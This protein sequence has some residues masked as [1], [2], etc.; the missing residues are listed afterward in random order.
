VAD[1]INARTS[2]IVSQSSLQSVSCPFG[3]IVKALSGSVQVVG[4]SITSCESGFGAITLTNSISIEIR[5]S[6]FSFNRLSLSSL[7]R[8]VE[9]FSTVS[10]GIF[11]VVNVAIIDSSFIGNLAARSGSSVVLYCNYALIR[12]CSFS[13]NQDNTRSA[14]YV[15]GR[16]DVVT[17]VFDSNSGVNN[18]GAIRVAISSVIVIR[19]SIFKNNTAAYGGAIWS[20]V[21][22]TM[23]IVNTRFVTNVAGENGGALRIFSNASSLIVNCSFIE[24]SAVF[25]GAVNVHVLSAVNFSNSIF[26]S[27]WASSEAGVMFINAGAVIAMRWCRLVNNSASFVGATVSILAGSAVSAESCHWRD[28]VAMFGGSVLTGV[29][30]SF[31]C[32]A[33]EF[34]SERAPRGSG[35]VLVS[36]GGTAVFYESSFIKCSSFDVGGVLYVGNGN[37]VVNNCISSN[38]IAGLGGSFATVNGGTLTVNSSKVEGGASISGVG[39]S[40]TVLFGSLNVVNSVVAGNNGSIGGAVFAS[41]GNVS[42]VGSEFRSNAALSG[43]ALYID[44][45]DVSISAINC[46]F[47]KNRAKYGFVAAILYGNV[48][49][50]NSSFSENSESAQAPLNLSSVIVV[51]GVPTLTF[52]QCSL[53]SI[54]GTTRQISAFVEDGGFSNL[55]SST[56]KIILNGSSI[57]GIV[58]IDAGSLVL[59]NSNLVGTL[60][61]RKPA[62]GVVFASC[63]I[64]MTA[65]DPLN[66]NVLHPASVSLVGSRV[67]AFFRV[68]GSGVIKLYRAQC[69]NGFDRCENITSS[70]LPLFDASCGSSVARLSL[71]VSSFRSKELYPALIVVKLIWPGSVDL[72]HSTDVQVVGP[73]RAAEPSMWSFANSCLFIRGR[74]LFEGN[75]NEDE[76]TIDLVLTS[77]SAHLCVGVVASA[78]EE[79]VFIDEISLSLPV[80]VLSIFQTTDSPRQVILLTS[81]ATNPRSIP[82]SVA[83]LSTNDVIKDQNFDCNNNAAVL[84]PVFACDTS[85]SALIQPELFFTYRNCPSFGVFRSC[86]PVHKRPKLFWIGVV[87]IPPSLAGAAIVFGVILWVWRSS[88]L[89][90]RTQTERWKDNFVDYKEEGQTISIQKSLLL[91]NPSS[92]IFIKKIGA[93]A[94]AICWFCDFEG[95]SV[96][97]KDFYCDDSISKKK[98]LQEVSV[99][100]KLRDSKNFVLL[101]KC[102]ITPRSLIVMEFMRRG[103]LHDV[104]LKDL[105]KP[106][107]QRLDPNKLLQ[108]AYGIAVALDALHQEGF[109][110]CDVKTKNILLDVNYDAK[111]SDFG[112]SRSI[113][114]GASPAIEGTMRYMAPEVFTSKLHTVQSDVYSLGVVLWEISTRQV[115]FSEMPS[116]LELQEQYRA[117]A[118]LEF[119]DDCPFFG[120][121]STFADLTRKCLLKDPAGRCSL[122]YLKR[123]LRLMI[124][125]NILDS[126]E[127]PRHDELSY[128]H[129]SNELTS[130][131]ELAIRSH[132]VGSIR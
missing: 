109:I 8:G 48:L 74:S 62:I 106:K 19:D 2:L 20:D 82:G 120:K 1:F 113:D 37:V 119:T 49:F 114:E 118:V 36:R 12:N 35:A 122:A 46:T 100:S 60:N 47:N 51:F 22:S 87:V 68:F 130:S 13:N 67:G 40:M 16:A 44:V 25:G 32:K 95:S 75:K 93:G 89:K 53:G 45:G 98:I 111:L 94:T 30:S 91:R 3:S 56:L 73:S 76:S 10:L 55:T 71:N 50:Q 79:F 24:N 81:S 83:S 104:L 103:S 21:L 131:T 92:I 129:H 88:Q 102:C 128:L 116:S 90:Q 7:S 4:L 58:D 101:Q 26:E 65:S 84:S 105:S 97:V 39:G 54:G 9:P 78:V 15:M 108:I 61:L 34:I 126:V 57:R 28:N 17:C 121:R 42:L 29:Q 85:V 80:T 63:L 123:E 107:E 14:L 38:A 70:P 5:A 43:G 112:A 41:G 33:C 115:P 27:N 52:V 77:S 31:R 132:N 117:H 72:S 124:K 96:V 66:A 18:G 59:I 125:D 69:V 110:H 99:H 6:S 23:T 11:S 86:G 127:D 64:G